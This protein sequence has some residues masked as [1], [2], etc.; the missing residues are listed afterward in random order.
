MIEA[1]SKFCHELTIGAIQQAVPVDAVQMSKF[2]LKRPEYFGWPQPSARSF[3]A[4]VAL[5]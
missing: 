4:A 2:R 5:I 3:R 1:E